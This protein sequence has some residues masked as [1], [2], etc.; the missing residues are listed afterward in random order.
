MSLSRHVKSCQSLIMV[1]AIMLAVGCTRHVAQTEEEPAV[2]PSS[3]MAQDSMMSGDQRV[4][5]R[6]E[7]SMAEAERRLQVATFRQSLSN[8]E[9][10]KVYFDFDK[11]EIRPDM[12]SILDAK[13][14]FL[15]EFQ[16]IRVQ[17]EGHCD[18]R[19]TVEYNIALGHRRSLKAKDYL[20]SLGVQPERID[21]V[22]YGEERPDDARSSEAAWA[23]NRRAEFNIIGGLPAGVN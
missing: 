7:T 23:K 3:S 19:G 5:E 2:K 6:R 10:Q 16:T 1:A 21:T 22:S 18:E 14:K 4:A 17:I 20:V 9:N 12:R 13:A 11:S 15:Q 8:F